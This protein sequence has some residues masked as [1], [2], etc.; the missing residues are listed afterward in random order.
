MNGYLLDTNICIFYLK[1][2]Y[3]LVEKIE[4]IGRHNC[5]ISEITVA[6]LLYGASCSNN[7]SAVLNEVKSF[8][9]LFRILSIYNILPTFADIK[10]CLRQQGMPIENFDLLIGATA[11]H[12]NLVMVTENVKHLQRLPHIKLENWI[13]R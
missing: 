13:K 4:E 10:A 7:K 5:Y 12:Y 11:V 9:A 2:K 6:E 3:N 8:I 1:G